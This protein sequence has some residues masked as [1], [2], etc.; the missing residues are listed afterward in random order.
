MGTWSAPP[1]APDFLP[2]AVDIWRASFAGAEANL[3]RLGASLSPDERARARAFAFEPERRRFL[4]SRGMLRAL[5]ARYAAGEPGAL[6]IVP[7]A[8]GKPRL[9]GRCGQGRVRFNV[10]HSGDVWTCAVALHREV[11]VDVEEVRP[12]Q[13]TDRIAERYFSAVEV[14]A[15]RSLAPAE[16][17]A[18]FH[19]G[20]ARKE[21][22]LKARG[23]AITIPLDSFDVTLAPG[24]P[25]RLLATR[26]DPAEAARWTLHDVDFGPG[27]AGALCVEGEVLEVRPWRI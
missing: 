15:L 11:G 16:R 25:P 21:A 1:A 26:P 2:D 17:P 3:D 19:R 24:E 5:L 14:A 22:F 9:G 27:F 8:N 6:E 20:W 4:A 18:A 7:D 13:E 23:V 12:G 10:S